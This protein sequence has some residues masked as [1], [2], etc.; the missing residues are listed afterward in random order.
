MALVLAA[1][2]LSVLVSAGLVLVALL[3]ALL[4]VHLVALL[5][6]LSAQYPCDTSSCDTLRR[7]AL[8][9]KPRGDTRG[10]LRHSVWQLP[11][12][13]LVHNLPIPGIPS[14]HCPAL[15]VILVHLQRRR[16]ARAGGRGKGTVD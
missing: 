14:S 5:E 11:S 4:V 16:R 10:S 13:L 6:L 1:G 8:H 12:W 7:G 15:V 2:C 9:D 3:V